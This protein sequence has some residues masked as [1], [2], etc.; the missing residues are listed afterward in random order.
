MAAGVGIAEVAGTAV[1]FAAGA[2]EAVGFVEAAVAFAAGAAA[3]FV[4]G[5][6]GAFAAGPATAFIVEARAASTAATMADATGTKVRAPTGAAAALGATAAAPMDTTVAVVAGSWAEVEVPGAGEVVPALGLGVGSAAAAG[7]AIASATCGRGS[8]AVAGQQRRG[9]SVGGGDAWRRGRR[10]RRVWNRPFESAEEIVGRLVELEL[11]SAG[12]QD[13][14]RLRTNLFNYEQRTAALAADR[15]PRTP[16]SVLGRAL[17]RLCASAQ[18][19]AVTCTGGYAGASRRVKI[20]GLRAQRSGLGVGE[21]APAS[22]YRIEIKAGVG[23]G[24]CEPVADLHG[25]MACREILERVWGM[26]LAPFLS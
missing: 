13:E 8:A 20:W 3:A 26:E 4:A 12:V 7:A 16:H 17:G 11:S 6:A 5:A 9:G 23:K 10:T 15:L 18:M 24:P 19:A 25:V 14:L 22:T 1:G 21:D 2:E